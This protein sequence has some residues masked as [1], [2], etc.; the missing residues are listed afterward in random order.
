[1]FYRKRKEKKNTAIRVG[2][3]KRGYLKTLLHPFKNSPFLVEINLVCGT[4]PKAKQTHSMRQLKYISFK[5][6]IIQKKNLLLY[7]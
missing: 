7:V 5:P 2:L 1:M 3:P 4:A 6:S